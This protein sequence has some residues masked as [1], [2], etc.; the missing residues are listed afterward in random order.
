MPICERCLNTDLRYFTKVRGQWVCR[1]C[2]AFQGE[3]AK[4]LFNEDA[5]EYSLPFK[6]TE[7]QKAIATQVK[8]LAQ[9]T[10]VLIH[11]VCGA[12]K[13]E[14]VME[15]IQDHLNRSLS[16][17]VTVARKQVALQLAQRF[18]SAFPS[19]KVIVVCEGHTDDLN[20][21]LI[22]TTTHQLYRFKQAFDCL[23]LDEP[24]AFPYR[25]NPVLNGFM[26]Q[27]VRGHIVYL[28]ATP[29]NGLLKRVRQGKMALVT[30]NQ[31][32][33]RFDLPIPELIYSPFWVQ[34][35]ALKFIL[36]RSDKSWLI[37]VP[38]LKVGQRVSKILNLPFAHA[39]C[40]DLE[41]LIERFK[42]KQIR[43]L[44]TTTVLERGVTFSD[45]QVAVLSAEHR[46]FDKAVLIQIAGRAG[47]DPKYPTGEVKFLCSRSTTDLRACLNDLRKANRSVSPVSVTV[48]TD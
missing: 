17:G 41:S 2:I 44:V 46:V 6:L 11:A 23:I 32:P 22:V 26:R 24:D 28:T 7:A 20:G 15:T 13:T 40:P 36:S 1:R 25:D 8:N 47:R 19:V 10:D 33:H 34:V 45:I 3:D 37:F 4:A 5:V 12:G 38:S 39:S 48:L 18:K 35:I 14:L 43:H 30:L 29:D 21:Q 31:R 9:T 27:A 42:T 16:I